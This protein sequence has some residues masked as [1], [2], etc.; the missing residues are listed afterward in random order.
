MA[1]YC[2]FK[3]AANKAKWCFIVLAVLCGLALIGGGV[4]R[5]VNCGQDYLDCMKAGVRDGTISQTDYDAYLLSGNDRNN[6]RARD[7]GDTPNA[8]VNACENKLDDCANPS[9]PI[10]FWL[11]IALLVLSTI[12][13]CIMCCCTSK[14]QT[15]QHAD[16]QVVYTKPATAYAPQGYPT[17][18]GYPE[19]NAGNTAYAPY[20]N[21]AH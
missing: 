14:P 9:V 7:L 15:L 2:G 19:N 12:P 21:T 8:A 16:A 1:C 6:G 20:P 10:L 11:G 18:A 13:C 5:A 17:A 3:T 4:G